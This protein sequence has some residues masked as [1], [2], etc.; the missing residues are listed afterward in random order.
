MRGINSVFLLGR[1]GDEPQVRDLDGDKRVANFS[2]ATGRF[3][4]NERGEETTWHRVICWNGLANIAEQYIHKGDPV[5][6]QGRIQ[7]RQYNDRDGNQRTAFEIVA[8]DITLLGGGNGQRDNDR[9]TRRNHDDGNDRR[10]GNNR[11]GGQSNGN[12][13]YARGGGNDR[14]RGGNGYAAV[15]RDVDEYRV[16]VDYPIDVF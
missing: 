10:G 6:V 14:N 9:D 7:V 11:Y 12:N 15:D 5:H 4:N 2:L 1:V 8:E 16:I 3:I 13:R